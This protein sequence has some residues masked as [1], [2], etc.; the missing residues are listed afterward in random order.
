MMP[1]SAEQPIEHL[2]QDIAA[3]EMRAKRVEAKL[4][5]SR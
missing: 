3:L 2:K 4:P 5:P 1:T